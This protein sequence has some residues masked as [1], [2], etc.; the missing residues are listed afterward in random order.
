MLAKPLAGGDVAVAL[1]NETGSTATFGTTARELGLPE[2]TGYTLRDLW[3]HRTA[4]T[5]GAVRASV[6]AHG[7]AMFRISPAGGGRQAP[8]AAEPG[9]V[10]D[11]PAPGVPGTLTP[12]GKPFTATVRATNHGRAPALA[13]RVSLTAP[14]GWR[15]K[16]LGQG[17]DPVL[18]TG[19]SLTARWRVVPPPDAPPSSAA[20]AARLTFR[21]A[22]H[23]RVRRDVDETLTVPRAVPHGVS[24]L[25][26]ASWAR[27]GNGY[28]PVERALS[29]GGAKAGDGRTL[30]INGK[31]YPKGLGTHAPTELVYYLGGRCTG[32]T[33]D[34]GVD[35][36]R[37]PR[38]PGQGTVTAELWADGTRRAD[39]AGPVLTCEKE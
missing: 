13:P 3:R 26:D 11:D 36:E 10:V 35:D 25:S 17:R 18:T 28:G 9:L 15:S 30:T 6:P 34:V 37:D 39:W 21:A 29:N 5:A 27:A 32:L 14:E 12:A 8:P 24:H 19:Q 31:T 33:T 1:C 22:G 4:E 7:T 38:E 20:L 23:G 2:R 16:P